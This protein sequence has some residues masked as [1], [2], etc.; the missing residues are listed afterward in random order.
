MSKPQKYLL[1][2]TAIALMPTTAFAHGAESAGWLVVGALVTVSLVIGAMLKIKTG[3]WLLAFAPLG[4]LVLWGLSNMLSGYLEYLF[5]R[6]LF[7]L[8]GIQ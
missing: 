7:L 8:F 4:I 6:S 5:R 1:V 2:L 3:R